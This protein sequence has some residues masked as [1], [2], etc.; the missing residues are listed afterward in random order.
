M[1]MDY[2]LFGMNLVNASAVKFR[3]PLP[4]DMSKNMFH[5]LSIIALDVLE[6]CLFIV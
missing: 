5:T 4:P 1:F 6:K 2:N 3:Q